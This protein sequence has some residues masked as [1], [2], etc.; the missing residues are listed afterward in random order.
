MAFRVEKARVPLDGSKAEGL[1]TSV[2]RNWYF[3][4]MYVMAVM[5]CDD[6]IENVLGN[7]K[8]GRIEVTL[9]LFA[10]DSHFSYED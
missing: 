8:Y 4:Q 7:N 1:I 9:E 10:N 6:E 3:P 2:D 5:D